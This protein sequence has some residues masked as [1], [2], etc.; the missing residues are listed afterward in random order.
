MNFSL[1]AFFA[2]QRAGLDQGVRVRDE[3]AAPNYSRYLAL[4]IT[5]GQLAYDDWRAEV[6]PLLEALN[7]AISR[8]EQSES[9]QTVES[10]DLAKEVV[11]AKKWVRVVE[12]QLR[13]KAHVGVPG[14]EALLVY[15]ESLQGDPD[16]RRGGRA[17][18]DTLYDRL[19]QH[20]ATPTLGF[21]PGFLDSA[22]DI[23]AGLDKNNFE[24]T[25][26]Q[27]GITVYAQEVYDLMRK[28]ASKMIEVRN[29]RELAMALTGEEIPGFDMRL[30]NAAAAPSR[31]PV[32]TPSETAVDAPNT[33]TPN[34]GPAAPTG[35]TG[36]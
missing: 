16:T 11:R 26:E 20:P 27:S 28:L 15:A 22:V 5:R 29:A 2:D 12:A 4:L 33:E 36:L 1:A 19:M 10:Q 13:S 24:M 14:A 21:E 18:I 25:N 7:R 23:I 31:A 34:T 8:R 3:L 35:A 32:L 30:I 17:N 6:D 9:G